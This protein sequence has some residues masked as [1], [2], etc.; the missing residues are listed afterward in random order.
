MSATNR[1]LVLRRSMASAADRIFMASPWA[2]VARRP[3]ELEQSA[4]ARQRLLLARMPKQA[5]SS[6]ACGLLC[7]CRQRLLGR[8]RL[9]FVKQRGRVGRR[10]PVSVKQLARVGR[11]QQPICH[12]AAA[13]RSPTSP[14][15][16]CNRR[17][18]VADITSSACFGTL[19]RRSPYARTK[20][21]VVD[22]AKCD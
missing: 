22:S 15:V 12:P 4:P 1:A 19:R 3:H 2:D 13:R 21:F 6:A 9:A 18:S 7:A 17:L 5:L 16:P 10:R 20:R 14:D 11:R 8:R